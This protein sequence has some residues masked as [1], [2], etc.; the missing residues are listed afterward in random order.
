MLERLVDYFRDTKEELSEVRDGYNYA[1]ASI[2]KVEDCSNRI[3]AG[4]DTELDL[5][6][7]LFLLADYRMQFAELGEKNPRPY[8]AGIGLYS[9]MH[10]KKH[11]RMTEFWQHL[12]KKYRDIDVPS[13]EISS[14]K[15]DPAN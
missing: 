15:I 12:A 9:L 3:L 14:E 10:P 8:H 2:K 6:S 13:E 11:K 4:T 1:R 7:I 5:I